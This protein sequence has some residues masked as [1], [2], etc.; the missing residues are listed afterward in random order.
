VI[1][2]VGRQADLGRAILRGLGQPEDL[3]CFTLGTGANAE[4]AAALNPIRRCLPGDE[5]RLSPAALTFSSDRRT[6][7]RRAAQELYDQL[8]AEQPVLPLPEGS[9]FG[10]VSIDPA[11]TLCMACVEACP[12]KALRAGGGAPKLEFIES[13]CHQCGLCRDLCPEKAIRLQPR[14]LCNPEKVEAPV[15]LH[16]VQAARC[17][18]CGAPF[19]SQAMVSRIRTNLTGHWMYASERQL[20]RL[21]MCRVCRTRDALMSEDVKVWNQSHVR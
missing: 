14:M 15:V 18:E 4:P 12:A 8:H 9:P 17:I 1:R 16:E 7:I 5:S 2:A 19:A 21:Q 13:R 11:C 20:R 3:I 10:A 6:L